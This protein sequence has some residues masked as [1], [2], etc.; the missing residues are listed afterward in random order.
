MVYNEHR[1]EKAGRFPASPCGLADLTSFAWLFHLRKLGIFL[2]SL[3]SVI[4]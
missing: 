3:S 4:G 2:E 1:N